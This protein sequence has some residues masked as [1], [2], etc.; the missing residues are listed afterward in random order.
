MLTKLR[1]EFA[2][3]RDIAYYRLSH[4]RESERAL[5][6]QFHRLYYDAHVFSKTWG[7]TTW[8]GVP[9]L[10]CPLD[11]WVY[12]ELIVE[13][14]PDLIIE[15]GTYYGGSALYMA[16][17]CDLLNHGRVITIDINDAQ[18]LLAKDTKAAPLRVRPDHPRIEYWRGSSVAPRT[19]D[20]LGELVRAHGRTMVILDS[21]H[22]R[23]HV[24]QELRLYSRWVSKGSY[25]VV[26]DT[27]VNGHPVYP[28]HGP[29]PMEALEAFLKENDDFAVDESRHSHMLTFNPRGYLRRLHQHRISTP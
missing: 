23:D 7:S 4:P 12:Q 5:V 20:H 10:K 17:L 6:E 24:L 26:E 3:L 11:L 9:A 18:L 16:S 19:L 22:H 29:G 15:T 25:L 13:V 2:T 21:D 14:K 27:N 1:R 28:G 8:L